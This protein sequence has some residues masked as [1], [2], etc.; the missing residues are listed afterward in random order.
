MRSK[1][2]Q[3]LGVARN[4]PCALTSLVARNRSRRLLLGVSFSNSS[5]LLKYSVSVIARRNQIKRVALLS[6]N[7]LYLGELRSTQNCALLEIALLSKSHSRCWR[8]SCNRGNCALLKIALSSKSRSC[9][10][11]TRRARTLAF[12]ETALLLSSR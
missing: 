6:A 11:Q 8:T 12:V 10:L 5:K 1:G 7:F 2:T 4:R 3:A 9:C